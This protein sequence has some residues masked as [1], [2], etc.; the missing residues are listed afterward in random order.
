VNGFKCQ[1]LLTAPDGR[2]FCAVY[3]NRIPGMT[4]VLTKPDG[5]YIRGKC[6]HGLPV[7]AKILTPLIEQGLCS[8]EIR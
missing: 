3:Q 6:N 4:I 5:S 7:E 1:N 2:A 8:M